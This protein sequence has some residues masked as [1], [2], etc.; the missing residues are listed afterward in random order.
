MRI[1]EGLKARALSCAVAATFAAF[2]ANAQTTSK[3]LSW[4]EF[5][6]DPARLA[7]FRE[8]VR[9]MKARDSTDA[10]SAEYRTSWRYWAAIHG[11][12]GN[13]A[14]AGTVA[15]YV[16]RM[17]QDGSWQP[18]DEK[19]FEGIEDLTP[20]DSI[21]RKVWD[22]CE[23]G[24]SGFFLWHRLYLMQFERVLQAA[25]KDPTLRLP[26]WDYTDPQNGSLPAEFRT[27][28]YT[29]SQGQAV[30]NPLFEARRA[31]DWAKPG[32]KLDPDATNID[33]ALRLSTFSGFQRE[34][35]QGIHGEVHC[36]M[37]RCPTP[38]MGAVAYSTN[39]PVFWLHHTNI[40][41]MLSCWSNGKDHRI[42][43]TPR[44]YTFVDAQ[45]NATAVSTA[46]LLGATKLPYSYD[47]EADCGRQI[48]DVAEIAVSGAAVAK[49]SASAAAAPAGP[50]R[51]QLLGT[52]K[53]IR[54]RGE[55]SSASLPLAAKS[56]SILGSPTAAKR[57]E[58]ERR[59][60]LILRGVQADANPGAS[61]KVYIS[62][63][64]AGSREYVGSFN[65]FG[66]GLHEHG[67]LP[68]ID[69]VFDITEAAGR[70]GDKA[71][72]SKLDITFEASTGRSGGVTKAQVNPKA[73]VTIREI[74][75]R[76]K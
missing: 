26:Y 67:A 6:K 4:Q 50:R 36:A 20:P 68:G 69:R 15:S 42:T 51:A 28:T 8:G 31:M 70:L 39:D 43:A 38:A 49:A 27:A 9:V 37:N 53:N 16:T 35:E 29:N 55:T 76:S 18:G 19:F 25:A 2:G 11:Y 46:A 56:K 62:V 60:E 34:I 24:T 47:K 32:T 59:T 61:Y 63:P 21:A 72:L 52:A 65:F 30:A 45:G 75:L 17:K 41:R 12:L 33:L 5:V 23:H 13:G 40:D 14:K 7:S 10:K 58:A 64:G 44:T 3:R 57:G 22:Q 71:D 54:V 73:T 48:P 74:Q 1:H 66:K